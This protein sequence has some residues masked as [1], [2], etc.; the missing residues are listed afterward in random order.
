MIDLRQLRANPE[1]AR[2]SQRAR[3][4]DPAVVDAILLADER[5]RAALVAFETARAE[6]KALGKLLAGA[7]GEDK[8]EFVARAKS[9]AADVKQAAAAAEAAAEA[10]S[11]VALTLP[12]LVEEGAPAGGEQNFKVLKEVGARRDFTA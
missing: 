9:L 7:K 11:D 2:V 4:A 5:H 8:A 10:L 1:A 3:E 6:Q 12:N